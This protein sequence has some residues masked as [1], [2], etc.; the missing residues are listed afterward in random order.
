M[1][2]KPANLK[3]TELPSAAVPPPEEMKAE[4]RFRAGPFAFEARARATPAG[5]LTVAL[6]ISA[7]LLPVVAMV[8]RRTS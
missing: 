8:R 7:V 2:D 5:L 1:T 4:A 6:L 3:A